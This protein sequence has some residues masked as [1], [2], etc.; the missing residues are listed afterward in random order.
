M[1]SAV[2]AFALLPTN[3]ANSGVSLLW[4]HPFP[5]QLTSNV[6]GRGR[7]KGALHDDGI[8][9]PITTN[10]R[11]GDCEPSDV[12]REGSVTDKLCYTAA[13]LLIPGRRVSRF[14]SISLPLLWLLCDTV[15]FIYLL[16]AEGQRLSHSVLS[17]KSAFHA[18]I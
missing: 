6:Q 10:E 4:H 7:G 5:V 11:L 14:S 2:G 18:A 1:L 15:F 9:P 3:T 12:T 16:A 8:F 13:A 17:C